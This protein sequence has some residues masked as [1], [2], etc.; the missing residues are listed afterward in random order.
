MSQPVSPT[1]DPSPP[2]P[3]ST[4]GMRLFLAGVLACLAVL[5]VLLLFNFFNV[6][7]EMF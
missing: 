6:L 2:L 5:H 1:V 7:R 4:V 3:P